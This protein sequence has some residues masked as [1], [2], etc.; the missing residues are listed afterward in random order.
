MRYGI[1]LDIAGFV[2]IVALVA[3][4]GPLLSGRRPSCQSRGEGLSA[5][6]ARLS[7]QRYAAYRAECGS[8]MR[9]GRITRPAGLRTAC[10]ARLG[11]FGG[12]CGRFRG[13]RRGH[14][15]A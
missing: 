14:C 12:A 6:S 13:C 9:A 8:R 10:L 5:A 2:V 7:R 1:A 11:E 3:L 15:L 4:V